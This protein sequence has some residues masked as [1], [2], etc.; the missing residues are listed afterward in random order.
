MITKRLKEKLKKSKIYLKSL[1]ASARKI[2][3]CV[4]GWTKNGL[5]S[6]FCGISAC[7]FAHELEQPVH[8]ELELLEI[9]HL[10]TGEM[11]PKALRKCFKR[12]GITV[13]K[14]LMIVRDNGSNMIKTVQLLNEEDEEELESESDGEEDNN[15]QIDHEKDENMTMAEESDQ[16][17]EDSDNDVDI[18]SN[19]AAVANLDSTL[20]AF[21]AL[22]E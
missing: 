16:D 22:T 19:N 20:L 15:E 13:T 1:I 4:H 8:I 9:S 21:E 6:S 2:T 12:W 11:L 3:I 10:H 5:S 14:V 17:D 7:F 18:K